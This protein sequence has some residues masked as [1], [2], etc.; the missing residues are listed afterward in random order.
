MDIS[1][2]VDKNK[3]PTLEE[4]NVAIGAKYSLWAE[5]VNYVHVKYPSAIDEWSYS[6]KNYGWSFRVKD[7]KRV[8]VYL[9]PRQ[10]F[11]KVAFMFGQKAYDSIMS[12]DIDGLIKQELSEARV[13][14]EGR[15]I[16]IDVNDNSTLVDIKKLID[17]KINS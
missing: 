3:I 13:Y 10:G 6:G 14:M 4:L 15:G 16:R 17:I 9:L 12:S 1:I 8:I 2:F 11:F 5:I 7:K